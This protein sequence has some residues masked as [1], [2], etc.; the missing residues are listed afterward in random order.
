MN[1]KIWKISVP[2][3]IGIAIFIAVFHM[4]GISKILQNLQGLNVFLYSL[5]I[6]FI[7]CSIFLWTLRW[8]LFIE[9]YGGKA[10][11][12]NLS[13]NLIVGLA[14][15][16]ITPFAK[17]GGEPVRAYLLKKRTILK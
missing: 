13:K 16:N 2:L 8:K 9:A 5:A 6:C 12:F 10:S 7:F 4:I 15:N 1:S 11:T 14:I 3:L 17:L